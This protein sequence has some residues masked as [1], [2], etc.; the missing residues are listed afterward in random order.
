[1]PSADKLLRLA[2]VPEHFSFPLHSISS[3][4]LS[5]V[6]APGGTGEMIKMLDSNQVDMAICLTEGLVASIAS[7]QESDPAS[8]H[9]SGTYV[10]SPLTWS[11]SALEGRV[12]NLNGSK[13]LGVSRFF[14][15]SHI[16][17]HTVGF[18]F[19]FK[20]CG[21][22]NGLL[23]ELRQGKID[24]FLWEKVTSRPFQ[25]DGIVHIEDVVPPWPAFMIATRRDLEPETVNAVLNSIQKS[26]DDFFGTKDSDEAIAKGYGLTVNDVEEW[27]S[28]TVFSSAVSRVDVS[29]IKKTIKVLKEVGV[30]KQEVG[31]EVLQDIVDP[32]HAHN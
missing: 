21:N 15:G 24:A 20:V 28:R 6:S 1:M 8:F 19:D 4:L 16:I 10:S 27:K 32:L 5:I 14:S 11:V 25:K 2:A 23:A 22:I 26:I 18:G 3:N 13:T 7:R 17:P 29:M 31:D 9:I 30:V 12:L